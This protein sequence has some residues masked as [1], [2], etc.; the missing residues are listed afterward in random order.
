MPEFEERVTAEAIGIVPIR[1][2]RSNLIDTLGHQVTQRMIDIG[3]VAFIMDG[4]CE[5][6]GQ[7]NLTV[8]ASEEE[9]PKVR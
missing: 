6:R 8:N 1:I 7:P 4:G 3:L 9:G 5:A 2:P